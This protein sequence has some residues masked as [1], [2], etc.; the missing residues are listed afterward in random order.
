M[1]D[2]GVCIY[3]DADGYSELC[4]VTIRKARKPHRCSE[5]GRQIKVG[6]KYEHYWGKWEG[7]TAAI[8]TCIICSEIA[9][10][11]YCDGRLYGGGLWDS[12]AY[13]MGELTTS[14]FDKLETPEAK[15]E[16]RRRWM[17]WK[18]LSI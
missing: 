13:V 16:L 8:D 7:E 4:D 12:M 6:E 10:A 15:A 3:A 17:A 11:F 14:C 18:G 5:C 1:S 9:N 2:C